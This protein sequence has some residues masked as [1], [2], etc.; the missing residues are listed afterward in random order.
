MKDAMITRDPVFSQYDSAEIAA[1]P[2]T[3]QMRIP[4]RNQTVTVKE[5]KEG[6]AREQRLY[7]KLQAGVDFVFR[8]LKYVTFFLLPF[9]ALIFK[10]LYRKRRPYYIDHLTYAMHLQTFVYIVLIV[11]FAVSSFFPTFVGILQRILFGVV[12]V[13]V[14]ISVVYLY[15]QS[16][17]KT[18]LKSLFATF[19]LIFTTII[20]ILGLTTIDAIFFQ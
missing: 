6:I 9:Y 10:L 14:L 17:W 7:R 16:W 13:Y 8:N 18:L 3:T 12:F 5:I 15:R 4:A 11:L 1:L 20:T 2:D 19:L